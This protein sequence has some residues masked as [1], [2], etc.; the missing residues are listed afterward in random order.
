MRTYLLL[1]ISLLGLI[2]CTNTTEPTQ[3][4]E[5][6]D[7][8]PTATAVPRNRDA[9]SCNSNVNTHAT[10]LR[11]HQPPLQQTHPHLNRRKRPFLMLFASL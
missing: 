9:N 8:L 1:L 10:A 7:E 5:T 11:I 6:A 2:S 3:V 4:A